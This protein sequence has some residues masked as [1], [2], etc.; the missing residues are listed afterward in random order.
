ML[1][2]DSFRV[3]FDDSQ[4]SFYP[5]QELGSI[6]FEIGIMPKIALCINV[7]YADASKEKDANSSINIT[8][9]EKYLEKAF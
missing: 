1:S 4:Q 8:T 7:L 6:L 9:S 5:K 2:I 3:L